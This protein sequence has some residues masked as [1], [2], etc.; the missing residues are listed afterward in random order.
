MA[1]VFISHAEED[2]PHA[3][4]LAAAIESEGHQAWH[5]TRDSKPAEIY[6]NEISTA[7]GTCD[8]VILLVSRPA[9]DSYHINKEVLL[10]YEQQKKILPILVGVTP[11][12][13]NQRRPNW[14]L[15]IG[16]CTH[17]KCEAHQ[18]SD[19]VPGVVQACH[20]A[21][22]ETSDER[23]PAWTSD[24]LQI[25]IES[26]DRVV[27]QTPLVK[28]FIDGQD[29]F[30]ISANKGI[31]KTLLLKCKRARLMELH[32]KGKG[33]AELLFIPSG[34]PYL[35]FMGGGLPSLKKPVVSL[36][37]DLRACQRI[38]SFAI[39]AAILA[40]V[41]GG[42]EKIP[43]DQITEAAG[44]SFDAI[45]PRGAAVTTVFRGCL[46]LPRGT[47][48]RLL[49]RVES[50]L[51]Y[52]FRGIHTGVCTFIDRVEQGAASLP[53]LAWI[54]VQAGL[55]EAAWD[56]MSSNSHVKIYATIRDEAF[57]T[58]ESDSKA[59]LSTATLGL[60]Y[61]TAEL[62]GMIDQ[63]CGL[64][65]ASTTFSRFVGCDRVRGNDGTDEDAFDHALRHTV[66][67][68]RDLIVLCHA[69]SNMP[70]DMAA[71]GFRRVVRDTAAKV[72]AGNVFAEMAPFLDCLGSVEQRRRLYSLLPADILTRD[73]LE[74]VC[75]AFNELSD[76]SYGVV[77]AA[78]APLQHPLCELYKCGLIG[79]VDTGLEG[80]MPI[81]Q[82]KQPHDI[83]T[84][85]DCCLPMADLYLL[86]PSLTAAIRAH[87]GND[88][89]LVCRGIVVGHRQSWRKEH[90]AFVAFQKALLPHR[91]HDL[92]R[93]I[94][95]VL[96]EIL[97][98][99]GGGRAAA[100]DRG[101]ASFDGV[102]E[103]QGLDDVWLAFD[104]LRAVLGAVREP[105]GGS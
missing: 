40:H 101:F 89:F 51:E 57:A 15:V 3:R 39:R 52:A 17:L 38:W 20:D 24:S 93:R 31:G 82:F 29:Q 96:E 88:G 44:V 84:C 4:S 71:D 30:F 27:F 74:Q 16:T 103:Q 28:R 63:L 58:Y 13:I 87:R 92:G 64:Y 68:P 102:L 94:G 34:K 18:L 75:M 85:D 73:E 45:V 6:V 100:A 19:I 65:E 8:L 79:T 33:R 36:L 11:D 83:V 35:D 59:N 1:N 60:R 105:G 23:A 99:R 22:D 81:Q 86:H 61:S 32:T 70:R 77:R 55:V 95:R 41:P 2:L 26:L 50:P 46:D 78:G 69:V 43:R 62:R 12:D 14:N 76:T 66:G 21:G 37:S 104:R 91:E 97:S 98:S 54:N 72:I 56:V 48:L 7:I 10:S 42:I 25:D 5:F 53:P 67:R 90:S 9:L 47:I 80:S 49:D